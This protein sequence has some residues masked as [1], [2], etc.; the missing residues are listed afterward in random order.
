MGRLEK[1]V[2]SQEV[3]DNL[4]FNN[5][6]FSSFFSHSFPTAS[7]SSVICSG[8]YLC[9]DIRKIPKACTSDLGPCRIQCNYAI[10]SSSI[11]LIGRSLYCERVVRVTFR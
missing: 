3:R 10:V 2:T 9:L 5:R 11:G 1:K 6:I 8:D 4:V 7:L